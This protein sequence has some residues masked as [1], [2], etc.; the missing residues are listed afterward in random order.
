M[1]R[2]FGR[3]PAS[4]WTLL[5]EMQDARQG[6]RSSSARPGSGVVLPLSVRPYLQCVLGHG[7]ARHPSLVFVDRADSAGFR[8]GRHS[9]GYRRGSDSSIK[10]RD[11]LAFQAR[12]LVLDLQFAFF[13]PSQQE[14]VDVDVLVEC[15]HDFVEVAVLRLQ[16][17]YQ[18][19]YRFDVLAR[20]A[21]WNPAVPVLIQVGILR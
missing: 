5:R 17:E 6:R 1:L 16:L 11:E 15:V 2:L 18:P 3:Y 12:N 9:S 4:Q 19:L 21:A 14:L 7:L 10:I 20:H 13:H 8:S